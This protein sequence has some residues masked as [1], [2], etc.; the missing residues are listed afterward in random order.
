MVKRVADL[1][2]AAAVYAMPN[3]LW[4]QTSLAEQGDT[5]AANFVA[6]VGKFI[7]SQGVQ[8]HQTN[9]SP[10]HEITKPLSD[11]ELNEKLDAYFEGTERA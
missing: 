11:A 9:V 6:T 4:A 3:I 10:I 5:K 1:L 8:V 7:R 2:Y